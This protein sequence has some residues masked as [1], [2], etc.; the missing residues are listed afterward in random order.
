M[1]QTPYVIGGL[2]NLSRYLRAMFRGAPRIDDPE[3]RRYLRRYELRVLL[4]GKSSVL[5]QENERLRK[6]RVEL[7]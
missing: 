3:Y 1:G 7:A 4:R 2:L 5:A 6:R